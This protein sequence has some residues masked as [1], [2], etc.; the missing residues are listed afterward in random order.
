MRATVTKEF[1]GKG[2]HDDAERYFAVGEVILGD[3]AKAA[4][5]AGNAAAD[6]AEKPAKKAEA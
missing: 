1:K 4:V 6:V 3:L 5:K 2:D